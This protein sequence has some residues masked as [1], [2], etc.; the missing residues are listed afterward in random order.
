M[1]TVTEVHKYIVFLKKNR[2]VLKLPVLVQSKLKTYSH[3]DEIQNRQKKK[4]VGGWRGGFKQ[5]RNERICRL[6]AS[7]RSPYKAEEHGSNILL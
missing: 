5:K 6:G 2:S 3:T 1:E 7:P 4:Q